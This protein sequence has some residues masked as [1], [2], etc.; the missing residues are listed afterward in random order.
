M[1]PGVPELGASKAELLVDVL[2]CRAALELEKP[3]QQLKALLQAL[4]IHLPSGLLCIHFDPLLHLIHLIHLHTE[5]SDCRSSQHER[6][7]FGAVDSN[8]IFWPWCLGSCGLREVQLSGSDACA[9]PAKELQPQLRVRPFKG[10]ET[11]QAEVQD[12][13]ADVLSH[14]LCQGCRRLHVRHL[15]AHVFVW[16]VHVDLRDPKVFENESFSPLRQV[17]RAIKYGLR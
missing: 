11:L 5:S 13:Q 10:L 3:N 1:A 4:V 15:A 7:F 8:Q 9:G 17:N 6:R 14:F 16:Q 2:G 12:L